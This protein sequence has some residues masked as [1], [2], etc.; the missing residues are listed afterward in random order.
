MPRESEGQQNNHLFD[1]DRMNI[2][3]QALYMCICMGHMHAI[4]QTIKYDL[5]SQIALSI[6]VLI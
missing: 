2:L 3:T 4:L 5:T 1:F 6:T